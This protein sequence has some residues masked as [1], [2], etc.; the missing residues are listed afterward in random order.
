MESI[1][2]RARDLFNRL[3]KRLQVWAF[4]ALTVA[5]SPQLYVDRVWG[6][7]R[8]YFF[9]VIF[10]SLL[11]SK[12]FHIYVNPRT[13]GVLPLLFWGPTFFVV[14]ILLILVACRLARSFESRICRDLAALI[15]VLFRLVV[16][17]T[18]AYENL[19][20][21]LQLASIRIHLCQYRLLRRERH[22]GPLAQNE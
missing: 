6:A 20:M 10:I 2:H 11:L 1:I 3:P 16:P 15:V 7:S 22:R 12:C 21:A 14:D 8:K 5:K 17:Y 4:F 19:L 13:V 9:S 18:R